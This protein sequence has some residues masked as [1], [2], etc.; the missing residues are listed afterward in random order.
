MSNEIKKELH[1]CQYCETLCY[2]NQCRNCHLKMVASRESECVDCKRKF[3]AMRKNGTFRKRCFQCQKIYNE[4][5]IGKCVKCSIDFHAYL[6][7]GRMYDKCLS[8]YKNSFKKCDRCDN[9]T[10]DDFI[11]CKS[12]YFEDR[13]NEEKIP[14]FLV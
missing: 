3:N 2:G 9:N 7:D 12:C 11:L 4:K 14:R 8:C 5:Y 10:R 1:P 6:D 13:T